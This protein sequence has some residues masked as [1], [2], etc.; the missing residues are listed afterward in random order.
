MEL[1]CRIFTPSNKTMRQ[2][3]LFCFLLFHI[4][5]PVRPTDCISNFSA[6]LHIIAERP[7]IMLSVVSPS[8]SVCHM[9]LSCTHGLRYRREGALGLPQL[10]HMSLGTR[11]IMPCCHLPCPLCSLPNAAHTP[12]KSCASHAGTFVNMLS[13]GHACFPGTKLL[14][15][16]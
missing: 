4:N 3:V 12:Q 11:D 15:N 2:H 10:P 1:P 16:K 9:A 5:M 8:P 14:T 7:I 13:Y 6:R